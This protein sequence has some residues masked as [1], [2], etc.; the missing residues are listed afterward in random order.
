MSPDELQFPVAYCE[1]KAYFMEP[2]GEVPRTWHAYLGGP[3]EMQFTGARHGP[4]RLHRVLTVEGNF[5]PELSQ[6]GVSSIPFF[7][8]MRF[9]GCQLAYQFTRA[10]GSGCQITSIEPTRS[11]SSWPY[12]D[13]PPLLPYI[14]L[15]LQKCTACTPK[16]FAKLTWQ[17]LE[18]RPRALVVIV[19]PFP[20]GGVS[21]WGPT[22]DVEGVQIIFECDL[23]KRIVTASNQCT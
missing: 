11:S 6:H 1:G 22:G 7:Y 3:L 2:A 13:Y 18:I 15:K 16:R 20:A 8:G 21:L 5:I 4:Q 12:A 17:G 14:P 23:G 10:H 19:P 9:S